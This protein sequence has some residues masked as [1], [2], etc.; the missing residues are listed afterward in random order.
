[1]GVS[2]QHTQEFIAEVRMQVICWGEYLQHFWPKKRALVLS[3]NKV[4][5]QFTKKTNP[6]ENQAKGTHRCFPEKELQRAI[7]L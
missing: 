3:V 2:A 6:V 5:I 4:L 7:N 1:M